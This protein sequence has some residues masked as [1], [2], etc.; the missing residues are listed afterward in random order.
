[1][2]RFVAAL[3]I[4][5]LAGGCFF[6]KETPPPPMDMDL[7]AGGSIALAECGYSVTTVDGASIPVLGADVLGTDPTPRFVHVT[8]PGDPSRQL[9]ILW[10]TG[11]TDTLASTVQFGENGATDQS[12]TGL[13]FVYDTADGL[14]RM[15][16]TH[17]CGLK[18]DTQYTYRVGGT[19]GAGSAGAQEAWSQ[20]FTF[21]TAPDRAT[22]PNAE[23]VLLV[24]GDTRDGYNTWGATL[25]QAFQMQPPD[26][27]LFNGD[28]V[29]LGLDQQEW[30]AWFTAAGEL[31]AGTPMILAHG[32][33]DISSVNWYSQ[34]ALPDD[35]QNYGVHFGPV[36]IT[37]ANDTPVDV[38]DLTGKNAQLLDAHLKEGMTA[39]W[40]FLLHHKPMW[41][42]AAGPHP[43]DAVT[44]RMAWQATVDA[45]HVDLVFN[46]HDH[47][48]E[49][50]KPM[51]GSSAGTTLAD[52]TVY[53]VVGSAGAALYDN[54]SSFW[55][56][57]SE[58]T[59]SFAFVRARAG[60]VSVNVFRG[61]G[62]TLDSVMYTK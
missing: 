58:K 25:K 15:H 54:G 37:V 46:G 10:R 49:R 36:H 62:S 61:D 22:S 23:V 17:L 11:D 59:F 2:L 3:S 21:R 28:A 19:S 34:F 50:T 20:T 18:P 9:A 41:T 55:T 14:V 27:I 56:E 7:H 13:T 53:F 1:M 24:L 16:E 44:V 33:H 6:E 38:A 35:E 26:A 12:K 57:K 40:N 47:D 31:L 45:D 43:N 32:N 8:V 52:G 5:S 30:D 4:A 29:L 48:Y 42:A 60:A 39:P 51:R